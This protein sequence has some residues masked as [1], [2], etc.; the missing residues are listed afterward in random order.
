[1]LKPGTGFKLETEIFDLLN[2]STES[3]PT[4]ARKP[5]PEAPVAKDRPL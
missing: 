3:H 4:G 5:G 1:M 2:G